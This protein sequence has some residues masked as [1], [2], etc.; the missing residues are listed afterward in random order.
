[1]TLLLL[2]SYLVSLACILYFVTDPSTIGHVCRKV[3]MSIMFEHAEDRHADELP[4]GLIE[5]LC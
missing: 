1:M 4:S 5:L 3:S 2:T